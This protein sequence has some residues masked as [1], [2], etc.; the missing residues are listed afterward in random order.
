M[1]CHQDVQP[2]THDG[3]DLHHHLAA[4]RNPVDGRP[5]QRGDH[6]ERREADNQVA[7]HRRA[8]RV[9]TEAEQLSCDRAVHCRIADG[10]ERMGAGQSA[11]RRLRVHRAPP[12]A[13]HRISTHSL[14]RYS[15]PHRRWSGRPTMVDQSLNRS[16][17]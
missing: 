3:G 2:G 17:L 13:E 8:L 7:Q 6:H 9:G 5:D 10:N 1:K 11:K 14:A 4:A 16:Y 12:T 15:L